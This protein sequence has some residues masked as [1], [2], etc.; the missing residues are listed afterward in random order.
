MRSGLL[1]ALL[2]GIAGCGGNLVAAP[3]SADAGGSCSPTCT[4]G[5]WPVGG[6]CVPT[7]IDSEL[8]SQRTEIV[9]A[10]AAWSSLGCG[11]LCFDPPVDAPE[12]SVQTQDTA[13]D[14]CA[15]RLVFSTIAPGNEG[16]HYQLLV[17]D[18]QQT[19]SATVYIAPDS[20]VADVTGYVGGVFLRLTDGPM[21]AIVDANGAITPG[22]A[23]QFCNL[24]G[25]AACK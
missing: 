20:T 24:Y 13:N 19:V 25:S 16:L 11:G 23:T 3:G 6:S 21:A 7:S 2:L 5:G 9:Q 8:S 1:A 12:A 14:P 4:R 17:N 10:L 18:Q 15:R 22:A